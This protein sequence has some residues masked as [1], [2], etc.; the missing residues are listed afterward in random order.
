[1]SVGLRVLSVC[2]V[3]GLF[4]AASPVL[5]QET[6]LLRPTVNDDGATNE[7]LPAP[8]PQLTIAAEEDSIPPPKRQAIDDPYAAKGIELG[9]I[10]LFPSLGLSGLYTSNVDSASTGQQSAV[11][12]QLRPTLRFAS[13]WSRHSWEGEASG[14]FETFL[15]KDTADSAGLD[16]SSKFRLD[17][18]HFTR[19]EFDARYD[20]TQTGPEDS[21]L[22][23][24]AVGNRTEHTIDTNAALIHDFGAIEG[25]V[26]LGL[27][28]QIFDDVKLTGG[29]REDN[30]DRNNYT[31]S[32]GLRVAYTEPPAL[33]PFLD[34]TYA[35]RF[36]DNR[37]DRN[38][39]ARDS[40]GLTT[41]LGVTLDN[42]PIWN[43]EAAIVY[44]LRDYKDQGL[45]TNSAFGINGNLT[46]APTDLTSAMLTLA[47]DLNETALATSSGSVTYSARVDVTHDLREN[48]K[49]LGGLGL[50]LDEEQGST[51]KTITSKLGLEWQLNPEWA[52]TASYDGTWFDAAT[53]GDSYNEQRISTGIVIRR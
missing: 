25:R 38:G 5:A 16:V 53:S 46:W 7:P 13:D 34:V 45:D 18:R 11:G 21:E 2:W 33:K 26:K 12:L 23:S 4:G 41:G 22:P 3:A 31:P 48:V 28:R 40:Q 17:I 10:T 6:D 37:L 52:W 39:L 43:G 15:R 42:G 50:S 29:G 1:V 35:P 8:V 47:T 24:T 14:N 9:G 27:E 20:L 19:A 30:A 49:L 51:D 36:H 32:L 44:T